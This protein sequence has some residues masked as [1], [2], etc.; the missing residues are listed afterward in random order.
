MRP[1]FRPNRVALAVYAGFIALS[2]CFG[3]AGMI[4]GLLPVGAP[5]ADR[6]PW[7]SPVFA[8]IALAL[9]VGLPASV[10]AVLSWRRHP[11]T[12][13]A[14]ALAGLLLVGWIA[15]ELTIAVSSARCK[16]CMP[17]PGPG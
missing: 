6:L 2:A 14:A 15:V 10:V 12:R 7:H 1:R 3:S 17:R 4:S 9:V 11:R 8:G 16:W 5:L 13:D